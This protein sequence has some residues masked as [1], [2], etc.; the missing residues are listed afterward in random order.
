VGKRTDY[1]NN[2]SGENH[3]NN[4]REILNV[5]SVRKLSKVRN[6]Y[7]FIRKSMRLSLVMNVI[8]S[9]TLKD[10]WRSILKLSM[11]V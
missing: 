1:I 4:I 7:L 11:G 8:V 3:S 9:S 10:C 5:M 2:A 6:S